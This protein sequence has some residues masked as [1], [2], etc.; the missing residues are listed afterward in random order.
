MKL[1]NSSLYYWLANIM[2]LISAAYFFW[3][4]LPCITT[5]KEIVFATVCILTMVASGICF[6]LY[7]DAKKS[8]QS[9]NK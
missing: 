7:T 6:V 8:E 9:N 3:K 4:V 1:K 2:C 5:S